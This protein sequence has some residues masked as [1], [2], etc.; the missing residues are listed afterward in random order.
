MAPAPDS[1]TGLLPA[2]RPE[3]RALALAFAC[4]FVLLGGYYILRPVRD[5]MATVLGVQQLPGL[6]TGT[7]LITLVCAPVFGWATT[8]FRLSRVVPGLFWFWVLNILAFAAAFEADPQNR[9]VA[10]T[11][12]WW[13]SVVN[14]FMIS[15]FWSLMADLFTPDQAMRLF[16][17]ISAG[18]SLGAIAGP[19]ATRILAGSVG[20]EGLLLAAAGSLVVV[21]GLVHLLMRE[22]ARLQADHA[23]TQPSTLDHRLGGNPFDGF[24]G[25]FRSGYVINQALFIMLMT[26]VATVAYFLQTDLVGQAFDNLSDRTRAIADIDLVVN[27]IS[28]L[29]LILGLGRVITRFGVTTSLVLNPAIMVL[30]FLAVALSPTLLVLQAVQVARRVG[31]YAIARPSREICFTVMP[32]ESRYRTKNVIDT[33]VYRFGDLT[34]AWMQAGQ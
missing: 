5:T 9:L 18:G 27:T 11:Y 31:Q 17:A 32:Q 34:A 2:S 15:A 1:P 24:A 33:V 30:A 10:T 8:R 25:L 13:F 6:Y 23:E 12:F 7:L 14:L 26:W 19:L 16:A 22:K 28:A 3:R 4:N 21:I 20:V 29:V